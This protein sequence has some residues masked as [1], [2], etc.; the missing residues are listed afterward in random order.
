MHAVRAELYSPARLLAYALM[1]WSAACGGDETGMQPFPAGGSAVSMAGAGAAGAIGSPAGMSAAGMGAA[2]STTT[3]VAGQSG[4]AAGRGFG[5]RGP[6]GSGAAGAAAGS[7]APT[8]TAGAAGSGRAGSSGMGGGVA[9]G[10]MAGS[11]GGMAV[12]GSG[13][14]VMGDLKPCP[15]MGD[16]K[17]LP[18]GDSITEDPYGAGA[19]RVP[20]FH[21]FVMNM[22][23]VTFVGSRSSGPAMVDGMPFPKKHEGTSGITIGGL[24]GKIPSPGLNEIPHIILLHIGTNDMYMSAAGAPDRL[25]T[26]LDGIVMGAPDALIVVAKI[27]PYPGAASTVK[28][29]NDGIVPVVQKRID[30][31]KHI[32]LIDQFEGFPSSELQDGVHPNSAGYKRMADKWYAAISKYLN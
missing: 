18:L 22:K 6:A 9:G 17:I 11:A 20:L 27:I 2:G 26:L 15:A 24:D 31:G 10:S 8:G 16:C 3:A 25:G 7:S 30:A 5:S 12:A 29:Y 19:Y 32:V 14:G 1:I 13:G 21:L 4:G 23:H 28:T